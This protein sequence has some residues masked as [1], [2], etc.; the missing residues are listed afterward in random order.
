MPVEIERK[1]LVTGDDWRAVPGFTYRQGYLCL[2]P[3]RTVRVRVGGGSAFLTVKGATHGATRLEFEYAIPADDV[4]ALLL[5]C[6]SSLV[7]KVRRRVDVS[8]SLWE[9]DEFLGRNQ[10]LV[11]AEIELTSEDQ[12][13]HRP[14]WLG[15][16]VTHDPRYYNSNLA[17]MPYSEWPA[18]AH[19]SRTPVVVV[20]AV[21]VRG[22]SVLL[23]RRGPGQRHAGKWEFPGGKVEAGETGE[24]A[25]RRELNEEF[26]IDCVVGERVT[27][28]RH[29]YPDFD[30]ALHAYKVDSFHGDLELR[31]HSQIEWVPVADL[32]RFDLSDADVAVAARVVLLSGCRH[33]PNSSGYCAAGFLDPVA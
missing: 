9:V 1:F 23:A 28:S 19:P 32:C 7:E 20:A 2:D 8:G 33:P 6:G 11:V 31:R 4:E 3:D 10:G 5:L 17:T 15:D 14:S 26:G 13:F 21:M 16:E 24:E 29:R 30:I 22:S 12:P 25:L 27:V 18:V